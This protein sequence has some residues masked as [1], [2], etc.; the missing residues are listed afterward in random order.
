MLAERMT[1]AKMGDR[2]VHVGCAHGGRLAAVVGKAGLS[3]HVVAVVPDDEAAS[4]A[5]RGAMSAGVLV[6]V[7]VAPPSRL[8]LDSSA[9]DLVVVDDTKGLLGAMSADE[10]AR[11][12]RECLRVLRPSGRAVIIS[13]TAPAGLA[14]LFSRGRADAPY[15]AEPALLAAGFRAARTLGEREGLRF[16]EGLKPSA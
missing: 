1:G 5:Q 8:P 9:F 11:A 16:V 7:Q 12:L 15:E 10:R 6:D 3:G 2:I 4:R 13:A 14:G